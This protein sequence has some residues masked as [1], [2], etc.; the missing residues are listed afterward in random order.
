MKF[1]TTY[2][3]NYTSVL[4]LKEIPEKYFFCPVLESIQLFGF[5]NCNLL[6]IM[7]GLKITIIIVNW[8]QNCFCA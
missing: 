1:N 5:D 8:S 7:T 6:F 3:K 2:K 4:I